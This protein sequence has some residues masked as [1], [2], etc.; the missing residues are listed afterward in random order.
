MTTDTIRGCWVPVTCDEADALLDGHGGRYKGWSPISSLT[1]PDGHYGIP[2]I[3]TTWW[4]PAGR[5]AVR[6]V[7][8]PRL[9]GDTRSGDRMTCEHWRGDDTTDDVRHALG[10][11][12]EE[13]P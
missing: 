3:S 8:H 1:D 2:I 13:D 4:D 12:Y 11:D 6:T 5:V 10:L 9:P 7:R